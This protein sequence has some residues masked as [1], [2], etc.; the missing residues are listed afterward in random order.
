VDGERVK[1]SRVVKE[2]DVLDIRIDQLEYRITVLALATQ[3]RPAKEA[4][5]LYSE[6]EESLR[7]REEKRELI[8]AQHSSFPFGEGKP[9]KKGRRDILRFKQQG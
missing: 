3:R 6:S 8:K 9:T 1:A 5:L 2:G 7:Q 4:Q